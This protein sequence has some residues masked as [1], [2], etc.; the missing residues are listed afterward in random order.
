MPAVCMPDSWK[1]TPPPHE[2]IIGE[3]VFFHESGMHTAG[4]ASH[5]AIYQF[6]REQSV[7]GK[8]GF[9]FGKHTGAA[10]V[11]HVLMA[12]AGVLKAAGVDI[13][14]TLIKRLVSQVKELR[15]A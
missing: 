14:D 6:I 9:I 4:I 13:N 15:K 3:G 12:N 2:P 11:E 8:H 7:G 1:K 5:P 10:A